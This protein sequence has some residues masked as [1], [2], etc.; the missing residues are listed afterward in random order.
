MKNMDIRV[1]GERKNLDILGDEILYMIM[2][3]QK[4]QNSHFVTKI[5]KIQL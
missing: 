5:G 3:T 4:A 1:G 2:H